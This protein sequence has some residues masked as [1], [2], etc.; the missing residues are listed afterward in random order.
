MA[1][2]TLIGKPGC[3]LCDDMRSVIAEVCTPRGD[4]VSEVSILDHPELE[5]KYW[6]EIPVL[7]V[8]ERKVAFWR[9]SHEQLL[10]AL[11]SSPTVGH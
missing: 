3:H 2:V 4:E 11:E 8:D 10:E 5:Q 7:L 1:R 9:I 6:E